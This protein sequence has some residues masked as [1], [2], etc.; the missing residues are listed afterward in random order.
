M[1]NQKNPLLRLV[2]PVVAALAG[3]G[4]V[5]AF[6]INSKPPAPT[7]P[8]TTPANP[9]TTADAGST[10][11]AE[12]SD[13]SASGQPDPQ[14]VAADPGSTPINQGEA[15][16]QTAPATPPDPSQSAPTS[17]LLVQP[18]GESEADWTGIGAPYAHDDAGV[19]IPGLLDQTSPYELRL[20]FSPY[21]AGIG[22]LLLAHHH[23]TWRAEQSQG[24]QTTREWQS[25]TWNADG[26]TTTRDLAASPIA[27]ALVR[28]TENG[29]TRD[30]VLWQSPTRQNI[31]RLVDSGENFATFEATIVEVGAPALT[32]PTPPEADGSDPSVPPPSVG[33]ANPSSPATPLLRIRKRFEVSPNSYVVALHQTVDNLSTRPLDVQLMQF[34]P[35]DLVPDTIGNQ[36]AG[37]GGDV[38]RVRIGYLANPQSDPPQQFVVADDDLRPRASVISAVTSARGRQQAPPDMWPTPESQAD[39]HTLVWAGMT[40]R[41]FGVAVHTLIADP[42]Q[43]AP[44]KSLAAITR[45]E[46]LV[47]AL[48]PARGDTL[49]ATR[50]T[51]ASTTLAPG[52]TTSA[53]I[54]LFAGPLSKPAINADPR[55]KLVGLPGLVTYNF[56][57][58]CGACTFS[59]LT[60]PLIELLRLLHTLTQDWAVAIILLVF[61]VRGA[62]HPVQKWSQIRTQRFGK[63]MQSMSP[64]L[65]KLQ[66]K[67]KDDKAKLQQETAKL[68]REEGITPASFVGCIPPFL[69]TPIWIALSAMIFFAV[70]LRH[71]AGFYGIFQ[72]IAPGWSFL[73]DLSKPDSVVDFGSVLFTVPLLAIPV[74]S[75]NILPLILALVFYI[76]QK[77]FT[78]PTGASVTPE[79]QQA[80]LISKWMMVVL[81]PVMMYAAPAGF[82]LYFIA[83]STIAIFQTNWIKKHITKHDLDNPEQAK[84]LA[85]SRRKAVS[86]SDTFMARMAR[87]VEEAQRGK[88]GTPPGPGKALQR[89]PDD[90]KEPPKRFKDR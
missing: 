81:F 83:N 26:T 59:W 84:V 23:T 87:R 8:A 78:P 1:P 89:R 2:V 86:T 66:E 75:L 30:V 61:C 79:Q 53:S 4:V 16:G 90:T 18:S 55:A 32:T 22:N 10:Q 68:W 9:Q 60:G 20:E 17:T 71:E 54:G 67:Y 21:G 34:G 49:L 25:T 27:A 28:I 52:G 37:Y 85:A 12:G 62:L 36:A 69:Q 74:S 48:S 77:T 72:M 88:Q 82:T 58:M 39:G 5:A 45:I 14:P 57:G 47:E 11:A 40:N 41:Y 35:I 7:T 76:H 51:G 13:P 6:F 31:W 33:S 70:E 43:P 44:A 24:I 56:G 80:Q 15:P 42:T 50:L 73:A 64:K 38:R 46:P 3:L 65:K 19:L 29:A 63:Q